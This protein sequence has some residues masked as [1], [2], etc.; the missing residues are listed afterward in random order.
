MALSRIANTP[1][2]LATW[3][4]MAEVRACPHMASNR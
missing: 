2:H 1:G 4:A 3:M